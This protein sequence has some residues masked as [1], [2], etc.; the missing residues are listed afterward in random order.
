ML[1][2]R[3]TVIPMDYNEQLKDPLWIALRNAIMERG[4]TTLV[5]VPCPE[6]QQPMNLEMPVGAD[7][8]HAER[9]AR[10]TVCNVCMNRKLSGWTTGSRYTTYKTN[11]RS[12]I[13]DA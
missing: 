3:F 2:L 12:P 11:Y 9:F 7:P 6:C 1:G 8:E 4:M 5:T 13:A 10:L